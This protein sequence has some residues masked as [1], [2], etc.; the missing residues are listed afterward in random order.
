MSTNTR[1]HQAVLKSDNSTTKKPSNDA[2]SQ[3]TLFGSSQWIISANCWEPLPLSEA[4]LKLVICGS[5]VLASFKT[6]KDEIE[7]MSFNSTTNVRHGVYLGLWY[8][9]ENEKAL[10]AHVITCLQHAC[11]VLPS[12]TLY[13]IVNFPEH[14]KFDIVY[15]KLCSMFGNKYEKPP[16]DHTKLIG[17][18]THNVQQYFWCTWLSYTLHKIIKKPLQMPQPLGIVILAIMVIIAL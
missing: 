7:G 16:F 18:A 13:F 2:G 17:I 3:K 4:N 9:G 14:L 1:M 6:D 5:N 10:L 15:E 11:N 8:Y 12:C